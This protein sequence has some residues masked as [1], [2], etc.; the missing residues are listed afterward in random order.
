MSRKINLSLF[1]LV[2]AS[3][4]DTILTAVIKSYCVPLIKVAKSKFLILGLESFNLASRGNNRNSR[5]SYNR[6]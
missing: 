4:L 5:L 3:N 2:L 1:E 6:K